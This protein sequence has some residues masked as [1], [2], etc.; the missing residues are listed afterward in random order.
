MTYL[1]ERQRDV[2]EFIE[3]EIDRNGVAPTLR[4]IAERFDF[5]STASAQKHI[6]LLERKGFLRREKHQ[7]RGLILADRHRAEGSVE[8]ELPL[9]G[10]VAAGSPIESM[11]DPEPVSVPSGFVRSGD[12]FV[13]R[14]RGESMVEDGIHDGDLVVVQHTANAVDGDMVVALVDGEVTLK[15]LFRETPDRIRL[16]PAN[17]EMKP[18]SLPA[19]AVTVQG[20]IVGL[21]RRY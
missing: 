7:K 8:L 21:L 12:H 9:L 14:V 2:L 18:M 1:T 10:L 3:R 19:E 13:L 4:E 11:P 16:Q 15:R 17:R 6:A 20:V 5:A